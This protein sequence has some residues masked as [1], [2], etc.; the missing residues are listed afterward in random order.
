[1]NAA[2]VEAATA[3]LGPGGDKASTRL[4]WNVPRQ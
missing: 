3:L 4:W 2:A 1:M